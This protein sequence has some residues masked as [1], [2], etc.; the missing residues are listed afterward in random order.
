[1]SRAFNG[2]TSLDMITF[3]VGAAPPDQGPITMAILAKASGVATNTSYML[4]GVNGSTAVF[5]ELFSNNA[6]A[7]LFMEADFGNGAAGIS[8]TDWVWYVGT[9]AS[10]SALPRWHIKD[11]TTNSAWTHTNGS[12]NVGDGSGPITA[13]RIGSNNSLG[14][15]FR[16]SI[17]VVAL[18]DTALT[19]LDVEAAC[20]FAYSDAVITKAAKWAVKLDQASIAT[21]VTNDAAGGGNQTAISG[22]TVD[23]TGTPDPPGFNYALTTS[24]TKDVVERYRVLNSISKDV[25]EQYRVTNGFTKDVVERY[26]VTNAFTKDVVDTYRVL[27][28]VTKDVVERYRITNIWAKDII[29]TYRVTNSWSKDVVERY[30]VTNAWTKDTVETYRILNGITKDVVERYDVLSGTAFTK[31]VL[32]RYRIYNPVTKDIV[33]RYR[34]LNGWSKDIVERYAILSATAWFKDIVERYSVL[35]VVLMPDAVVYLGPT[36]ATARIQGPMV[37]IAQLGP[38]TV[39]ARLHP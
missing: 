5:S 13:I 11:L 30:R 39:T 19:D 4:Q 18:W 32:E 17:A 8:A 36:T 22:T 28:V 1:M 16:G 14:T 3:G 2:G 23:V 21:S 6:G 34:V 27:N 38:V 26:R 31:D 9:K 12:A 25:V 10:G 7:K 15:T 24:F 33:E 29:E 35:A 37:V 20:T